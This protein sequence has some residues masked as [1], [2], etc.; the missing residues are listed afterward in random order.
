MAPGELQPGH[1]L[2]ILFNT[3][4]SPEAAVAGLQNSPCHA[5]SSSRAAGAA[6]VAEKGES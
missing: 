1:L 4:L 2:R 5:P 6:E 3:I